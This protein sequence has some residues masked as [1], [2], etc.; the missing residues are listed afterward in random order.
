MDYTYVAYHNNCKKIDEIIW[1]N[2]AHY[3][4]LPTWL[5]GGS[6]NLV[7]LALGSQPS[8]GLARG[9]GQEEARELHLMLPKV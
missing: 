8:Q 9:A 3:S 2:G 7:T 1:F 4:K 6:I 5:I